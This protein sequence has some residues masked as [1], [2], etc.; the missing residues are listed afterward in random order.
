MLIDFLFFG[1]A[2]GLLCGMAPFIVAR[3]R[4]R[5]EFAT[6]SLVVCGIAGALF[7]ILLAGPAALIMLAIAMSS[8]DPR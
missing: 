6:T 4:G 8:N 7:G 3:N 1:A 2:A 5:P